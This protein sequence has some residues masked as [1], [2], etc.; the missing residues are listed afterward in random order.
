MQ[1]NHWLV[2]LRYRSDPPSATQRPV[3]IVTNGVWTSSRLNHTRP[4]RPFSRATIHT[5]QLDGPTMSRLISTNQTFIKI[6]LENKEEDEV[7]EEERKSNGIQ[8]SIR[9]QCY[10]R[11]KILT[12]DSFNSTVLGE[13]HRSDQRQIESKPNQEHESENRH[14]IKTTTKST[15]RND[16]EQEKTMK[17]MPRHRSHSSFLNGASECW[18][19]RFRA[20]I[21][22]LNV[23]KEL[24]WRRGEW[25]PIWG[26]K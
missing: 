6:H 22:R 10:Q 4:N 15:L 5:F 1:F 13:T 11:P 12:V 16:Y 23:E 14:W 9:R 17:T 20:N 25:F 24:G 26:P 2:Q 8:F 18:V 3:P 7:E 19:E 21:W